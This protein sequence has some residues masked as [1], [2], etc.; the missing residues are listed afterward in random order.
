[1]SE[2]KVYS[3]TNNFLEFKEDLVANLVTTSPH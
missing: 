2:I 3:L 1:M